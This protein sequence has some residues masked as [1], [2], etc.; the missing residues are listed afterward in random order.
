[1]L[2]K[3]GDI[4]KIKRPVVIAGFIGFGNVGKITVEYLIDTL[5]PKRILELY[6]DVMPHMVYAEDSI[7]DMPKIEFFH[8]K[9]GRRNFIIL[10]SD[11]QPS[12]ESKSYRFSEII[13]E[14][15][16][17]TNPR[18]I[19]TTGGYAIDVEKDKPTVYAV[20][21]D[22]KILKKFEKFGVKRS[23]SVRVFGAAGLLIGFSGI[24]GIPA[25]ALLAET[26][27]VPYYLGL[28]GVKEII[29]VLNKVYGFKIS[30]E[31]LEKEIEEYQE[32]IKQQKEEEEIRKFMETI[33]MK[34]KLGY[35]R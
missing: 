23:P 1:M 13:F 26:L 20:G 14:E 22:E 16:L 27:N 29:N 17:K 18:E 30:L 28:K 4:S 24:K 6:S 8:L 33:E 12:E 31:K 34:K 32:L 35:F 9:K 3:K 19:I 2:M 21:T 11:F 5:E 15:L 10:T 7:V 25:V